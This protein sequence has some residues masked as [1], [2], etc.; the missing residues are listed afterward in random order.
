MRFFLQLELLCGPIYVFG[1]SSHFLTG[2]CQ[3]TEQFSVFACEENSKCFGKLNINLV[4]AQFAKS[5]HEIGFKYTRKVSGSCKNCSIFGPKSCLMAFS[6][7][8][9]I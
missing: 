1:Q 2:H 9:I 7:L 3:P 5:L 6:T 4:L 8:P